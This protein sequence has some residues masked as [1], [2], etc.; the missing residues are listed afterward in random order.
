MDEE[1]E[2]VVDEE[3]IKKSMRSGL[4]LTITTYTLPHEMEVHI[5]KV[6]SVFLKYAG[7]EN[8]KD[9]IEYCIQELSVNAKKANTKRVYF[10]EKGLDI[11]DPAQYKNGMINFKKETLDNMAH[12]LQLQKNNGLYIKIHML[13]L[14]DAIQI[15][16]RNN[17]I[18][19]KIEL[20]RIHDKLVRSRKFNSLEDAFSQVLDDSEG[21][22]LGLVVL[23]LMLKKM[24]LNEHCFDITGTD[25]ET[26][27][28]LIVPLEATIL[29]N[30]SGIT[31]AIVE[32]I[33]D[34]PHF[35]ENIMS[36]QSLLA[37][38]KSEMI[39]IASKISVDPTMTA[40]IIKLVNS[41]QYMMGKRVNSISDAVKI[42]GIL[43]IKN[44]LYS[45]GTQKVLGDDTQEK[46]D[47]WQHSYKTAYYA[48][49][50]VKN[51][52]HAKSA[53]EDAYLG[54]MLH[55]IGKIVLAAVHPDLAVKIKD[56]CE[57]R[58]IPAVT[59]EDIRAG[60]N[61]AEVGALIAEKWNF[62]ENLV[63]AIRFHHTPENAPTE[64]KLLVD[65]VYLANM[66]C[67]I[68]HGGAIYEQLDGSVLSRFNITNVSQI[69][70][71]ISVFSKGFNK[72]N[73]G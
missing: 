52:Q 65:S 51:F 40:D 70:K 22:G 61:H 1:Q 49:N 71:I 46:K 54:G 60:M 50:L 21:A 28:R 31:T 56:F 26:I 6:L 53:L 43:G 59:L 33:N 55:D 36:L 35:P 5:N 44:M 9:Y 18:I 67:E 73:A 39:D 15:E 72:E 12:Y 57:C 8:L 20:L 37:N 38:P 32:Q 41:A 29:T 66:I 14:K 47:L 69:E 2:L 48:F 10:T 17:V 58:N 16:V 25:T 64:F 11:S 30:V 4:P 63:A 13:Y 68:E 42:L 62:P 45:Y 27:A 19:S 34:L 3:K 24:G 7:H 23:I